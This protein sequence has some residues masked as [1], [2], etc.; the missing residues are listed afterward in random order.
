MSYEFRTTV[1]KF[2]PQSFCVSVSE[3]RRSTKIRVIYQAHRG[4]LSR[5]RLAKVRR[6]LVPQY[7]QSRALDQG[8]GDCGHAQGDPRERGPRG[9]ARE[10]HPRMTYRMF[11]TIR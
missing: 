10:G 7:L 6:T 1:L 11:R 4:V 3:A 9:S 5:G 2:L 8:S